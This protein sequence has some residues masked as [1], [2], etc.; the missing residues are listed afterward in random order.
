V[1]IQLSDRT[2]RYGSFLGMG[3]RGRADLGSA[4]NELVDSSA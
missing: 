3:G 2:V 4:I 1:D